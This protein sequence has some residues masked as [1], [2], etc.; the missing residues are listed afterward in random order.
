MP[1]AYDGRRSSIEEI[2]SPTSRF[3]TNPKQPVE[4]NE[5]QLNISQPKFSG[6]KLQ[7]T[8]DYQTKS[9][10]FDD[11]DMLLRLKEGINS[12]DNPL[13]RNDLTLGPK[14]VDSGLE[15][16]KKLTGERSMQDD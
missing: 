16:Q 7:T 11:R 13:R 12:S 10:K 2:H 6:E 9:Q 4:E 3:K 5:L 1:K 15:S 8:K 14:N